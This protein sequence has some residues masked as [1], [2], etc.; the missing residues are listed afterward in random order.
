MDL[1]LFPDAEDAWATYLRPL[2][3]GLKVGTRSRSDAKFVKIL[4]IG[5]NASSPRGRAIMDGAQMAFECY[6]EDDAQAAE[7]AAVVRAFVHAAEGSEIAP[8]VFFKR[9][10]DV[11]GPSNIPDEEHSSSRY[12]FT[13]MTDLRARV[14]PGVADLEGIS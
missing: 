8:G 1:L 7:F 10:R 4:R 14:V 5:G 12:S 11:S 9:L 13:V 3:G 6:A 2:L